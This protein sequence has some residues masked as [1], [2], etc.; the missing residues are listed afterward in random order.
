MESRWGVAVSTQADLIVVGA[1]AGGL[2]TAIRA[3]DLGL[4]PIIVEAA[5]MVGGATAFSGGQVWTGANH[6]MERI[7]VPDSL[8]DVRTYVRAIAPPPDADPPSPSAHRM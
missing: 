7:G 5:A 2:V 8:D 4:R 6:V 3:H 1:G